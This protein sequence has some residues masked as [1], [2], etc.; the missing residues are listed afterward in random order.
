M[1]K[2]FS[3]QTNYNVSDYFTRNDLL[4]WVEEYYS[5]NFPGSAEPVLEFNPVNEQE[6]LLH[7]SK[8]NAESESLTEPVRTPLKIN[9]LNS[10]VGSAQ[11]EV[12]SNFFKSL[13]AKKS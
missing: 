12:L 9:N 4:E 1:I 2:S 6:F 10:S 5:S 8:L 7:F 13:L 3:E 11:N